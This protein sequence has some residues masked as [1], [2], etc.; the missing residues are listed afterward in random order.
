MK[1][2]GIEHDFVVKNIHKKD[3]IKVPSPWQKRRLLLLLCLLSQAYTSWQ[4]SWTNSDPHRSGFKLHTAVLSVLLLLFSW[5]LL[6]CRLKCTST[7]CK[8]SIK[9]QIK[10]KNSTNTN[11]LNKHN[12]NNMAGK[13]NT[14]EVLWQ[15]P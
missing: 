7:Y 8:T 10:H 13:S 14:L 15:K 12:K 5:Y 11:T 4:F 1:T 2:C 6:T 3:S 9:S